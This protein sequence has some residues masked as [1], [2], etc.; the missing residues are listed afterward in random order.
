[1]IKTKIKEIVVKGQFKCEFCKHDHC[2]PDEYEK[3]AKL[4]ANK[5][6]TELIR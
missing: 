3:P 6:V 4:K 1:M 5:I 2:M